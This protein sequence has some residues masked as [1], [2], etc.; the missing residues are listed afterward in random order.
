MEYW[1]FLLQKQGD[2]SWLPLESSAVEILEGQYRLAARSSHCDTSVTVQLIYRGGD[3]FPHPAPLER[4]GQTTPDGLMAVLPFTQFMPGSWELCCLG[5]LTAA[6]EWQHS[7]QVHVL[8]LD[9]EVDLDWAPDWPGLSSLPSESLEDGCSGGQELVQPYPWESVPQSGEGLEPRSDS[10]SDSKSTSTCESQSELKLEPQ[11]KSQSNP[12][13]ES[14]SKLQSGMDEILS[15]ALKLDSLLSPDPLLNDPLNLESMY[16]AGEELI[17]PNLINLGLNKSDLNK[18]G[19]NNPN[20]HGANFS[21]GSSQEQVPLPSEQA[22][23]LSPA[24]QN[25]IETIWQGLELPRQSK[26]ERAIA[27]FPFPRSSQAPVVSQGL[28]GQVLGDQH[29]VGQ[30]NDDEGS[31]RLDKE[32]QSREIEANADPEIVPKVGSIASIGSIDSINSIDSTESI[33]FKSDFKSDSK[34]GQDVSYLGLTLG[35][36]IY[37]TLVGQSLA[38]AGRVDWQ[39]ATERPTIDHWLTTQHWA[40]TLEGELQVCLFSA[41]THQVLVQVRQPLPLATPPLDFKCTITIPPD[42]QIVRISGEVSLQLWGENDNAQLFPRLTQSFSIRVI[43]ESSQKPNPIAQT[44]GISKPATLR[45]RAD[46]TLPSHLDEGWLSSLLNWAPKLPELQPSLS[47]FFLDFVNRPKM[48]HQ[49]FLRPAVSKPLPPKLFSSAPETIRPRSPQLPPFASCQ[50][51]RVSPVETVSD[52]NQ[53][54]GSG[55]GL[56]TDST[57]DSDGNSDVS[58]DVSFESDST[59]EFGGESTGVGGDEECSTDMNSDGR[60]P[61]NLDALKLKERFWM[62]LNALAL[63][64]EPMADVKGR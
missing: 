62:Q 46:L 59:F 10:K 27:P 35:Q 7:L 18:S 38:I 48:T 22:T 14:H 63:A 64:V 55:L 51:P 56:R 52:V 33:S 32:R 8:P 2:R 53:N 57:L 3:I 31:E 20:L 13:F 26:W 1:E 37:E 28:S 5:P 34:N 29:L 42:Y 9:G 6:V 39:T 49:G 61:H 11:R 15:G 30:T 43:Q 25:I 50:L 36:E 23:L 54:A 47:L 58:W 21:P 44:Q 19:S 16:S 24:I 40:T 4:Q 41:E 17:R 12:Q 60:S 45:K